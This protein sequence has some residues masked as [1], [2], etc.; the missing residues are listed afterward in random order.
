MRLY[1]KR[2][3]AKMRYAAANDALEQAEYTLKRRTCCADELGTKVLT[4]QGIR[5]GLDEASRTIKM[6]LEKDT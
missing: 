2:A 1:S 6:R 3:L 4:L 5:Y